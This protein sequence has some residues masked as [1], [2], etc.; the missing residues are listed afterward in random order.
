M[1]AVTDGEGDRVYCELQEEG[2]PAEASRDRSSRV[3][4]LS[5]SISSLLEEIEADNCNAAIRES[6]RAREAEQRQQVNFSTHCTGP[7][8]IGAAERETGVLLH[9]VRVSPHSALGPS[10]NFVIATR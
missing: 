9:I 10:N 7:E 2:L 1:M 4:M 6:M 5:K 8:A 3:Q